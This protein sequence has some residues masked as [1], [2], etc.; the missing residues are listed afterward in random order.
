M[1]SFISPMSYAKVALI[2]GFTRKTIEVIRQP[3]YDEKNEFPLLVVEKAAIIS[4]GGLCSAAYMPLYML[5]DGVSMEI[6]ARGLDPEKYGIYKP[7]NF[8]TYLLN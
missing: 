5:K 7:K 1:I 4:I 3:F 2:F 8:Y 6:Y